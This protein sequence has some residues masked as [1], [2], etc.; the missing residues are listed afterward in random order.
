MKKLLLSLL[1]IGCSAPPESS[2]IEPNESDSVV[3]KSET[4]VV[5]SVKVFKQADKSIDKKVKNV[6][7]DINY[8]KEENKAL[9]EENK[10]L[11]KA[12]SI[13]TVI[14]DTIYI[15]ERKNF[16]GKT[17]TTKDSSQGIQVDTLEN[18]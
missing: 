9:V 18:Q 8:L 12:S 2:K 11:I 4:T 17:K 6:A 3:I 14:R 1:L 16:W 15:T 5:H 13:K 10:A 7:K